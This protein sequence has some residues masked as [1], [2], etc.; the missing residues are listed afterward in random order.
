M[1]DRVYE[2]SRIWR[3]SQGRT[4]VEVYAFDPKAT[5]K[6]IISIDSPDTDED[7]HSFT[8]TTEEATLLKEFL[9]RKGY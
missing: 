9:I 1:S 7:Y 2:D 3:V 8:L 4:D 6:V 5:A